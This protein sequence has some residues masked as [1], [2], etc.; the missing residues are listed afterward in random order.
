VKL[1]PVFL[2]ML[3]VVVAELLIMVVTGF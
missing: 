3:L 1:F 2:F